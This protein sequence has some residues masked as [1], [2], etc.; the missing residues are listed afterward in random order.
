MTTALRA[1][2]AAICVACAL[3]GH[4][5]P[6]WAAPV[7]YRFLPEHSWVQFEVLHFGTSTIRGR[8]GP[9]D[10]VAVLDREAHR[11]E[12]SLEINVAGVDTGFKPFDARLREPDL[13]ATAEYP[14]AWFVARNFS[15]EGDML[16]EVRGE[17]TFRGVSQGLNL[18]AQRFS[19][20]AD[21]EGEICGGDFE[22]DLRRSDFGASFG[23]PLVADAVQL[24]IR[25]EG[26]RE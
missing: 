16:R 11:G 14:R 2:L 1:P 25:V 24:K 4:A 18:R 6:A 15:F 5:A 23:V 17:F 3:A 26:R 8:L 9:L 10:G 7:T 20:R 19:C 12:V 13:L 22:A 21:P